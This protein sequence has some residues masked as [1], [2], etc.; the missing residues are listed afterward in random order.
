MNEI[1]IWRV[2]FI[3]DVSFLS[4]LNKLGID[5]KYWDKTY[6]L[7]FK[8]DKEHVVELYDKDMEAIKQQ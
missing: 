2:D 7:K 1:T 3:H 4:L 6:V 5:I 8:L